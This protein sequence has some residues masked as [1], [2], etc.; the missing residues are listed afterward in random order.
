MTAKKKLHSHQVDII[1]AFLNSHLGE[2]VYIEQPLYFDNGNKNQVLL[3]LQ[4]LYGLKQP[5]RLWFDTFRDKMKELGFFQSLYDSALY[6]N[7]QSTYVAVYID[8]LHIVAPDL[9]LI[10]ELK[11]QL[12]S[13]FKTT[14][15]GATAYY[16]EMKVSREEDIIIVMQTVYIDQLLETH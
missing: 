15:L 10:N 16:L 1:T 7:S 2:K 9:S 6:F 13:K 3:S 8:D 5:A 12:A 4:E 11:A 14:N